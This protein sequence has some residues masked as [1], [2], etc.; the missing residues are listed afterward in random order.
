MI[1]SCVACEEPLFLSTMTEIEEL[2]QQIEE[3]FADL[4]KIETL[5]NELNSKVDYIIDIYGINQDIEK[6]KDVNDWTGGA[7]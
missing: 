4:K 3:L 1:R 7:E 5:L 2:F 6:H